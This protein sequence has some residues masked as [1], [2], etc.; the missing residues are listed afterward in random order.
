M[1]EHRGPITAI[2]VVLVRVLIDPRC[3]NGCTTCDRP[4]AD[5]NDLSVEGCPDVQAQTTS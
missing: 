5:V 2:S 3:L 4:E 1:G